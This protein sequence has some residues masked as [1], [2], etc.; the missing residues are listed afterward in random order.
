M[1][2]STKVRAGISRLSKADAASIEGGSTR[3]ARPEE[4]A[5]DQG[6]CTLH[7]TAGLDTALLPP[8]GPHPAG[9]DCASATGFPGPPVCTEQVGRLLS[10]QDHKSQLLIIN[11]LKL[12]LSAHS[13]I[14]AWRIP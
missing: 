4:N 2:V 8:R 11:I 13:S 9:V 12:L 14:L 7:S 3:P 5:V 10:F 1:D 6:A